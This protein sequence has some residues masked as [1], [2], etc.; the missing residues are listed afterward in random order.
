MLMMKMNVVCGVSTEAEW[1]IGCLCGFFCL[2]K[3]LQLQGGN[4][5][6]NLTGGVYCSSWKHN[7]VDDRRKVGGE[8]VFVWISVFC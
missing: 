5:F 7:Q 3:C 1:W 8:H 2:A 6:W 4:G